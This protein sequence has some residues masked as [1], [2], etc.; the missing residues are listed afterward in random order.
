MLSRFEWDAL[1]SLGEDDGADATFAAAAALFGH[2]FPSLQRRAR[3]LTALAYL[4]R[5]DVG[6][7]TSQ[8][9]TMV[10]MYLLVHADTDCED[11]GGGV[12]VDDDER[13]TLARTAVACAAMAEQAT[14]AVR[15][16]AW[17]LLT[18]ESKGGDDR[19]PW[20]TCT[21]NEF[22][23]Q[24][25]LTDREAWPWP[26]EPA[27]WRAAFVP[28]GVGAPEQADSLLLAAAGA[29][30]SLPP[31]PLVPRP[32]DSDE[33]LG[34][35]VPW[36][37]PLAYETPALAYDDSML[38]CDGGERPAWAKARELLAR[39]LR[40]PLT[41][42]AQQALCAEL[43][44]MDGDVPRVHEVG[45]RPS[46]LPELVASNPSVAIEVLLL[47]ATRG[48]TAVAHAAAA[49]G[50]APPAIRIDGVALP[51]YESLIA[52]EM[53]LHSME[54]VH[55]LTTLVT[56]PERF[57][58]R[59]V[60]RCIECCTRMGG[61]SGGGGGG[62]VGDG[63]GTMGDGPSSPSPNAVSARETS[64]KSYMQNRLVRLICV[65]LERL[66]RNKILSPKDVF[67]ESEVTRFCIEFSRVREAA[68][69]FRLLS[70]AQ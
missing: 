29:S 13:R 5:T 3:A 49:S 23:E 20:H 22:A 32:F 44:G 60:S 11:V 25:L 9:A 1:L 48:D 46:H 61:G 30:P 8:N 63:G 58:H 69:L 42:A 62:A 67:V 39:A 27:G 43:R 54:V 52:M 36:F 41:P 15:A 65:F 6:Q 17:T 28:N 24:V 10:S 51:F 66:I 38:A 26:G 59:F 19:P 4:L 18:D 53:S 57:V 55:K 31:P 14:D 35:E 33:R 34:G 2:A 45:L 40:G 56:L 50:A 12:V 7:L 68:A 37:Y 70:A 21:P 16:F 47:L 64:S